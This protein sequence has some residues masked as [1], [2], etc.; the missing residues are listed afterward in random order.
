MPDELQSRQEELQQTNEELEEKARLLAHQNQEVERKNQEVEQARQALEDKARQLALTSKYKS[1]FLANMS[2]ELRTP[3]NSLLILSDQLC[4]NS[5]R[6]LTGKQVEF[7]KTIHSSGNEL[8]M[9]INDILDLSKIE[10]G[11]VVLEVGE[12]RIEEL[13]RYVERTFRHV[14]ESKNVQF[15]IQLD[16]RLPKSIFTDSKRLQQIIKNLLSNAF[17]F[18][19]QGEVTLAIQPASAGWK[20]DNED[21]N[22]ATE[23][24]AFSVSDTG[25]GIP[26]DK[27]QIVFEAFQQADGSTSRKYGGTGLG[28]AISRELSRLLHG[29]IRLVSG[30]HK[31]SV[32]TLYLPHTH[33]A[34]RASR[35]S[36]DSAAEEAD[37]AIRAAMHGG[38]RKSDAHTELVIATPPTDVATLVNEAGDDRDIIR[39]GDRVLLIIENDLAF[40]R[41]L[42]DTAREKGFKGLVTSMG[43][44][45]LALVQE[46]QPSAIT[47][48]IFLP[49]IDGWRVLARL[50]NDVETRHI[51]V[52]V[53]S[54]EE[55]RERA[56]RSGAKDF[57]A[58]PIQNKQVLSIMLDEMKVFLNGSRKRV[59]VIDEEP[60]ALNEIKN[61]I[62]GMP[63]VDILAAPDWEG[64]RS[65]LNSST[66][67]C[68][69]LG[70]SAADTMLATISEEI[71]QFPI[72]A[73]TPV[74]VLRD[75]VNAADADAGEII[76]RHPRARQ[77]HSLG[78]LLDQ[79]TMVLHQSVTGLPERHRSVL[80]DIYQSNKPLAGKRVLIVDDDIRN[81]FALSSVLEEY[82]MKIV[83]AE[84]GRDAINILKNGSDI[85]IVL[86]D[87]MMPELDGIDTMKQIRKIETCKHLPIVAVTAK[88]MKGDRERCI[89]AGAWDYLSKPVERQFLLSVL[90]AWLQR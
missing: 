32:F 71:H 85:D 45:A 15:S 29:E 33:M 55:A 69:V 9:L 39:P 47:L 78:R 60:A 14:A 74:V 77:V 23:V 26:L 54:T 46:Y 18:T 66:C 48:D 53:I 27:Q 67:D 5:E 59:L 43:A 87:I 10:S 56:V 38:E 58:K 75:G 81:I 21:L 83:S 52:Y 24:L 49:D 70:G 12:L 72:N 11:T 28:L 13:Q 1:E 86:M 37:A 6:N 17:K 62:D 40:A 90:R 4:I 57:V 64:A 25:I 73:E 31:G 35:K 30:P 44:A 22:R 19:Y 89:E 79:T 68:I 50:K 7:A 41:F 20:S 51:P 34:A 2:H 88:A 42:L 61:Y 76:A 80:S 84:N 3:L 8:L 63:D 36:T 82:E 16:P 65:A